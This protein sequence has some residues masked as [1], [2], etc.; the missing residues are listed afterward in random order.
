M[1]KKFPTKKIGHKGGKEAAKASLG[2]RKKEHSMQKDSCVALGS[3][4]MKQSKSKDSEE[5]LGNAMK[6]MRN[7]K[8]SKDTVVGDMDVTPEK[9]QTKDV[10]AKTEVKKTKAFKKRRVS[11]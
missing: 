8:S 11:A 1:E 9:K 2:S 10:S 5:P 3:A 7:R 4:G 6:K